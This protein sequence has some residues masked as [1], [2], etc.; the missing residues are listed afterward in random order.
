[1]GASFG[2]G[3][4]AKALSISIAWRSMLPGRAVELPFTDREIVESDAHFQRRIQ[5]FPFVRC[6][7]VLALPFALDKRDVFAV[8]CDHIPASSHLAIRFR[9]PALDTEY[10]VWNLT[11][12]WRHGNTKAL[13][14][15][16]DLRCIETQSR[17]DH[18]RRHLVT[19]CRIG[20]SLLIHDILS[21]QQA[22][23]KSGHF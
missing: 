12:L 10:M 1:M 21:V 15:A 13:P 2:N 11:F 6:H 4:A 14:V 9:Y 7:P 19:S 20:M 23:Q 5:P 18:S 17:Y 16:I 3:Q 8:P 22:Q